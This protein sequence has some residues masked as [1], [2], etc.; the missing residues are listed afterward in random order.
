MATELPRPTTLAQYKTALDRAETA[1]KGLALDL[2][3]SRKAQ[4]QLGNDL[5]SAQLKATRLQEQLSALQASTQSEQTTLRQENAGLLTQLRAAQAAADQARADQA[6]SE[7]EASQQLVQAHEM[8]NRL[9]L[10]ATAAAD[11]EVKRDKA[12]AELQAQLQ[13]VTAQRDGS[14]DTAA[15]LQRLRLQ[16][17]GLVAENRLLAQ[18]RDQLGQDQQA[19]LAAVEGHRDALIK[20]VTQAQADTRQQAAQEIAQLQASLRLGQ[21]R[22][23]TLSTQLQSGGQLEVLA[24]EQLGALMGRFVQQV[25]GGLP[26]LKLAEGELKL[27]LGLAQSGQAQGFVILQPG[28]P[29]GTTATVHEV[30]LK[31]DRAGTLPATPLIKP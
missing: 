5:Q 17:D 3:N 11:R 26:S 20:A 27:K 19:L 30:A 12:L 1:R 8:L 10:E 15:E 9:K 14:S 6:R 28:A 24:P 25:E 13:A 22:L 18:T 21:E 31:F 23:A 29:A 4:A 16:I 2:E 7:A